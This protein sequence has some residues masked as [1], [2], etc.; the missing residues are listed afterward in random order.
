[1]LNSLRL[2]MPVCN[3]LQTGLQK[4]VILISPSVTCCESHE[5]RP[6]PLKI[7][8]KGYQTKKN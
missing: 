1:M 8:A 5:G 3:A 2:R 6:M 4:M 7:K